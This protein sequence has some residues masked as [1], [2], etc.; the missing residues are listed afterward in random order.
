MKQRFLLLIVALMHFFL[1][2]SQTVIQMVEDMGVYKIPCEINGLKVKMVF[3]TGA[4]SVCIS[5]SLA[6]MMIDNGYL[7]P[8]EFA[9]PA[10]TMTADGRIVDNTIVFL[11]S[12]KLGNIT[13]ENVRAVVQHEQKT[14]L[15]FGQ[16]AIQQLGEVA[17]KGDKLYIYRKSNNE[18]SVSNGALANDASSYFE[19]W[20]ATNYIY[21]NFTYSFGWR[22]PQGIQWKRVTGQEKHT[23]FRAEGDSFVAHVNVRVIDLQDNALW[24][25]YDKFTA[26]IEQVDVSVEKRLGM[27]IYER[28]F[29]KCRL[30]NLQSIKTT[31]KSYFKDV[32]FKDAVESYVEQYIFARNGF[33][34]TISVELPKTIYESYACEDFIAEIFQGFRVSLK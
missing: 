32:R 20:D 8:A 25:I 2:H 18:R 6:E 29:E 4:A 5:Q 28:T 24:N 19:R 23:I 11:K 15:L 14:P 16:S 9:G 34:F 1:A 22:L 33:L 30:F 21:S 13:L 17:I 12:V 27:M 10:K 31:C 26:M 3:D 7:S